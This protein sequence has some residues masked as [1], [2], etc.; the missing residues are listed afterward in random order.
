MWIILAI[1]HFIILT[2][3]ISPAIPST[4]L[5]KVDSLGCILLHT[6]S[7]NSYTC[8]YCYM[9]ACLQWPHYRGFLYVES[10][11]MEVTFLVYVYHFYE[12]TCVLSHVV[13]GK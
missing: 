5:D 13:L 3:L 6:F 7:K 12:G 4:L 9:E 10:N 1:V 2:S 8:Q 11:K